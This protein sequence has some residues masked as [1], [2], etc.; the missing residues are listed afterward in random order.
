VARDG[1]A[2]AE[3]CG[4]AANRAIPPESEDDAQIVAASGRGA[5]RRTDRD[6]RPDTEA[7][8]GPDE[9]GEVWGCRA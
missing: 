6:R 4:I 8:S 9:I 5:R 2:S 7:G 1:D 3:P